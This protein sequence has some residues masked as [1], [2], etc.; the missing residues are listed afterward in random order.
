MLQKL[1]QSIKK[2]YEMS[3]ATE[4]YHQIK[5]QREQRR[6]RCKSS[7]QRRT[8]GFEKTASGL[9]SLDDQE[10]FNYDKVKSKYRKPQKQAAIDFY[11][12]HLQRMMAE[13]IDEEYKKLKKQNTGKS[14]DQ[15]RKPDNQRYE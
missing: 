9:D 12:V 6:K 15:Y 13:C 1:T 2:E 7:T 8:F 3:G 11:F 4:L 14:P 10:I 5:E